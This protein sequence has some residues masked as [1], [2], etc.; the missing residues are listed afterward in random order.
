MPS[1]SRAFRA[2]SLGLLAAEPLRALLDHVA[3]RVAPRP[4]AI[5]DGHPVVVY[6]GLAGGPLATATL[7]QFLRHSGFQAH[8]WE[9]GVNTGPEGDFDAWLA[10]WAARVRALHEDT[11]RKV[12]LVGWSLG[13]IYAREIARREPRSVR[14]VI[15]LACPFAAVVQGNH[16]GTV[17][18]LLNRER[19]RVPADMQARLRQPPPVPSSSIYS[20]SD[21]IVSWRACL[22][23]ATPASESIE[24]SASHL[25]MVSHPEVLR[26]V[27]ERL[28]QPEGHWR[29][30]AALQG[31]RP[32]S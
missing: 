7:R 13:G 12:S 1:T 16:A 5:G 27:A 24:V 22:E 11:G 15:T 23:K 14:Q 28:A 31:L 6:P 3:A 9:G 29:P 10:P 4:S 21:G 18:R 2:P 8:D 25:G 17:Y 32:P 30:R 20:R 26:I 19:A